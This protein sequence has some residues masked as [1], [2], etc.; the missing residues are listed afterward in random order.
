MQRAWRRPVIVAIVIVGT[1][2]CA[3]EVPARDTDRS[4]EVGGY[5]SYTTVDNSS[6]LKEA[7][8]FGVRG[9]YHLKA[10]HEIEVDFDTTTADDQVLNGIEYDIQKFGAGYVR[11]FMVKG[12][13][14]VVPF[15]AF[16]IG[17]IDYDNG[18]DGDSSIFYRFGGGFKY[19][20]TPRVGFRLD[21]RP[22]RW[23]GDGPVIPRSP[24]WAFDATAGVTVLF[25]GAK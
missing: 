6:G 23:R 19:F 16:G 4:W 1:A 3:P 14:K 25:G 7:S 11:N 17:L 22:Y 18:T 20:F 9:G 5:L 2:V 12:H 15:A 24:Y 8:G 13:E 21:V 10:V